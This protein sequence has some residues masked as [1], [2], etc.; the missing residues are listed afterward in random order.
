M[1]EHSQKV[2]AIS[3]SLVLNILIILHYKEIQSSRKEILFFQ[4][5]KKRREKRNRNQEKF[6]SLSI[7]IYGI[8][9]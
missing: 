7:P 6:P 9:R 5:K 8:I 3:D 2:M 4:E 1:V